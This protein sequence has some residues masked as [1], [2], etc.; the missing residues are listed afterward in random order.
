MQPTVVKLDW[1]L[2]GAGYFI[3]LVF[4][5]ANSTRLMYIE[6]KIQCKE[7]MRRLSE[8]VSTSQDTLWPAVLGRG[9][10][11]VDVDRRI[12]ARLFDAERMKSSG[13][14]A[15]GAKRHTCATGDL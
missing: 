3:P 13:V 11:T 5:I 12:I 6:R 14:C 4:Y 2:G 7:T 15:S 10:A 8:D 9:R 1:N